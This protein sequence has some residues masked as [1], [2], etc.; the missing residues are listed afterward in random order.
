MVDFLNIASILFTLMPR[1]TQYFKSLKEVFYLEI[2]FRE[3]QN[4]PIGV[5][6]QIRQVLI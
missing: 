1:T 5:F 6:A 4:S 3:T 2:L